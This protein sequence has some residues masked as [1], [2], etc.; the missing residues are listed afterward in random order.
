ML[1]SSVIKEY[2]HTKFPVNKVLG[3]EFTTN[4]IFVHD[5]KFHMSINMETGL[6]Q[7]FKSQE[8]G[9]FPQLIAAVEEIPYDQALVYL[10]SKLFDTPEHLFAISSVRVENQKAQSSGKLSN[11]ISSFSRF[12]PYKINKESLVDRLARKFVLSRKLEQ[13]NFYVSYTGRYSNR[14]IIPYTNSGDISDSFYFQARNLSVMGVK[15]L[16]PS[17]EVTGIKSSDILFPYKQDCDY[18]FITEGPIDAMSLQSNGI[19]A[20]CTQGSHLSHVQAEALRGMQIIFAYDNDQAGA[21]GVRQ[22]RRVLLRKNKN[23]FCSACPPQGFK[24]WNDLHIECSSKDEFVSKVRDSIRTV[25]FE[26]DIT[27]ALR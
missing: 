25:D 19:N 9:N 8:T 22:A 4:S 23:E 27:E 14:I 20:T 10:R 16:N 26:Y 24:D 12:N 17:R 13:F 1:P 15:Y 21:E 6:W 5:E 2:L 3:Q 7:D 11:I 18:I